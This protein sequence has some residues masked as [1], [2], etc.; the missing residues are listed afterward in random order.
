MGTEWDVARKNIAKELGGRTKE[1]IESG[2][3]IVSIDEGLGKLRRDLDNIDKAATKGNG[4][5]VMHEAIKLASTALM[6]ADA[7]CNEA[8]RK[9]SKLSN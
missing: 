4:P 1:A 9:K 2:A 7:I 5:D 6:V 8:V 3:T